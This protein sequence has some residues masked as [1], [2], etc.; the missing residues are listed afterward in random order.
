MSLKN[1]GFRDPFSHAGWPKVA[2][3]VIEAGVNMAISTFE[4]LPAGCFVRHFAVSLSQEV[5]YAINDD[6]DSP[7]GGTYQ[8]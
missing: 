8:P 3:A 1:W 7:S 5:D 2:D 6:S 4:T